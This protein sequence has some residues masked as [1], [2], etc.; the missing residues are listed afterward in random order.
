MSDSRLS[1]LERA[2]KEGDPIARYRYRVECV[3]IG[4]PELAGFEVG[5]KVL[6]RHDGIPCIVKRLENTIDK[7][8]GG[9]CEDS[10]GDR[11]CMCFM[12]QG[13]R[14]LLEPA[15]PA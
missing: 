4:K 5:D 10:E 3:R 14:I 1:E 9:F 12:C 13:A 8:D 15:R 6:L 7:S 11:Y 2:S